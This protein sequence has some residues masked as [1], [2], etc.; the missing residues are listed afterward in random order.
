MKKRRTPEAIHT[1]NVVYKIPCTKP[2][3]ISYIGQTG[4]TLRTRVKQHAEMCRRK[5]T[6]NKLKQDK[7]DNGLA[8]HHLKTGHEFDLENAKIL[9]VEKN[10]W[11]RLIVEG[12]EIRNTPNTANLKTGFDIHEIWSPFLN[13]MANPI[14]DPD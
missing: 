10:Y 13:V 7:K 3:P 1:K 11:R 5:V 6:A 2:C 12:I 9:A 8:Y 4:K 14:H